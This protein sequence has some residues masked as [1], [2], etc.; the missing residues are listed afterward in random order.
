MYATIHQPSNVTFMILT[1]ALW[2]YIYNYKDT[3]IPST[4]RY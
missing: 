3:C 1:T 4:R 2:S